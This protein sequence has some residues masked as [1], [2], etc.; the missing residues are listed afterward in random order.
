MV[1]IPVRHSERT[2]CSL[3][4]KAVTVQ[5]RRRWRPEARGHPPCPRVSHSSS[6]L[7]LR[8]IHPQAVVPRI[9]EQTNLDKRLHSHLDPQLTSTVPSLVRLT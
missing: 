3:S 9:R 5:T 1:L 7:N 4:Y 8:R 6:E 2:S